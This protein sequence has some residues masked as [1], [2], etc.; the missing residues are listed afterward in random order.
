MS[1]DE[2]RI[3][4]YIISDSVGETAIKVA[5]STIAQFPSAKII[6]HRYAFIEDSQR[7][8]EALE[9]TKKDEGIIFM[10]LAEP[11]MVNQV[12]SFCQEHELTFFNLIQPFAQ[13]ITKRTGIE[14]SNVMGA[15]YELSDQYFDRIKAIEFTIHYDD[16]KDPTALKEADIVILGV[17]RTGK[18][19][20]S[21]YL[22][23]LGYKVMN[24]PLIPEKEVTSI[25]YEIDP[26]K[27]IGLTNDQHTIVRH[28]RKRMSE[29][30]ISSE[31]K[32]SSEQRVQEELE[33]AYKI[34]KE[35]G[36]PVINVSDRSIE[37]T[38][39]IILDTLE[40]TFNSQANYRIEV[41]QANPHEK[42]SAD[43]IASE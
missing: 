12:E 38:A 22:G 42:N 15:Q 43:T 21:M 41:P 27:I 18:T 4:I 25:L 8:Q 34:Y 6:L 32:Y 11:S 1:I 23:T 20:I 19:P 37:E 9:A 30:G 10:T 39:R 13:E 16:G 14:P 33:Y 35:L 5:Q 29:Y 7:L 3:H 31:T 26:E 28:R 36:C 2:N 40:V 24:L 17:S